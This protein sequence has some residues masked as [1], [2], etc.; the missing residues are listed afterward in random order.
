MLTALLLFGAMA[1]FAGLVLALG[2]VGELLT[3]GIW[4][5][6]CAGIRRRWR[7]GAGMPVERRA[8]M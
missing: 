1:L 2:L 5:A 4:R 7:G 6:I 8:A 3:R